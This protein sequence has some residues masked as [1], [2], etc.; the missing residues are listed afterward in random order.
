MAIPIVAAVVSAG[1]QWLSSDAAQKAT[2]AERARVRRMLDK[3]Q[4]PE[5]DV[6]MIEP[7]ELEV[8]GDYVPQAIPL[9]QEAVPELIRAQSSG[10][11]QGRGAQLAALENLMQVARSGRDPIVAAQEAAAARAAS[12]EAASARATGAM[13][14]QRRGFGYNPMMQQGAGQDA[15]QRMALAG[16][17]S[18]ADAYGRRNQAMGQAAALG[19]QIFG[20]DT[21][22][23]RMNAEIANA[24]NRRVADRA[25][26]N[27]ELNV[28]NQNAAALRN[29]GERQRVADTN[30]AA[31]NQAR[32]AAQGNRNAMA[33]QTYQN[34]LNKTGVYAGQAQ[35]ESS[36]I[37]EQA[38][39]NNQ[40][41]QSMSDLI[42]KGYM[43]RDKPED[44]KKD[45]LTRG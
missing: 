6:S 12:A 33:Q 11:Q 26:A 45:N 32:V 42:L 44:P 38:K 39:Q 18:A 9:I 25:Q 34:K 13:E 21:D 5:F 41:M 14:A 43:Y 1:G 7:E 16:Q 40:A 28:G 30:V 19:G 35:N 8:L 27:M 37:M 2:A 31:R 20:Q 23:E 22:I 10:A 15:M 4:D 36:A 17:Q 29:L 3:I 24:F